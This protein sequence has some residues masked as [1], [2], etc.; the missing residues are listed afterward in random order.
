MFSLE[1]KAFGKAW[2]ISALLMFSFGIALSAYQQGSYFL[3][4]IR[5]D[6]DESS[7]AGR[8]VVAASVFKD[9][10]VDAQT[11]LAEKAAPKSEF[12]SGISVFESSDSTPKSSQF[13]ITEVETD[14]KATESTF[15]ESQPTQGGFFFTY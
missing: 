12:E 8:I 15:G 4:D 2:V 14:E 5:E 6:A 3:F 1:I 7:V 10:K 13:K 11:Q 9:K